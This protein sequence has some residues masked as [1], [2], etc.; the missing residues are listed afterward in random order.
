[1]KN[2]EFSLEEIFEQARTIAFEKFV[3]PLSRRASF[4]TLPANVVFQIRLSHVQ[5]AILLKSRVLRPPGDRTPY[6]SD[7]KAVVL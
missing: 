5:V 7:R 1:M 3:S 6:G 2:N 4:R